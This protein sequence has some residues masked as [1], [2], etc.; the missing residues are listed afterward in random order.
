MFIKRASPLHGRLWHHATRLLD[1]LVPPLCVHCDRPLAP[2]SPP[3]CEECMALLVPLPWPRC[4]RCGVSPNFGRHA[5]E[6]LPHKSDLCDDCSTHPPAFTQAVAMYAYEGVLHRL[7]PAIKYG[8]REVLMHNLSHLF[9]PLALEEARRWRD[10]RDTGEP[11]LVA[12]M[13]MHRLDLMRRGFSVPMILARSLTR[14]APR[15]FELAPTLVEK[16][17]RTAPQASLSHA[18]R[19]INLTGAMSCRGVRQRGRRVILIDDVLTTGASAH[20][21]ACAL[22]DAGAREVFVLTLARTL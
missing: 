19:Q 4:H 11:F 15:E 5:T 6:D 21:A 3:L 17:R 7:L 18:A 22:L 2:I 20:Q 13:P 8:K 10:A 12:P 9:A 14:Q 1:T 16:V